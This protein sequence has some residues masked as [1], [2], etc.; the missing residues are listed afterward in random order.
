MDSL[1]IRD[2]V[3]AG[4]NQYSRIFSFIHLNRDAEAEYLQ[5]H[6]LS[7]KAPLE[8]SPNHMVFVMGTAV[9]AS[10]VKVGDILGENEVAGIMSVKRRGVYAPVTVSGDIFVS[11]VLAS[12]YA[13]VRSHTPINQHTEA[14]ALFSFRRLVCYFDFDICKSETY[15]AGFP[16]WLSPMIHFA[17]N[18]E[19]NVTAQ[20]LASIIGLPIIGFALAMEQLVTSPLLL[21]QMIYHPCAVG[22]FI[23]GLLLFAYNKT[24]SKLKVP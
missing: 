16:D 21:N 11:G 20:L 19:Q 23:V 7:F 4:K 14:H 1:Q 15:T 5:I 10:Q 18:I 9:P 2:Y 17:L 3:R 8:I 13:A 12:S 6:L 22:L 24:S